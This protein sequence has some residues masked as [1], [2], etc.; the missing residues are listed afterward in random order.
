MLKTVSQYARKAM[1][2]VLRSDRF[3]PIRQQWAGLGAC[4]VYHRVVETPADAGAFAPYSG[5][6]VTAKQFRAQMQHVR[7]KYRCLPV[8]DLVARLRSGT[9]ERGS[10]AIT[11][12]DGYR[13]NLTVAL[14]ILEE[15]GIPATIFVSTGLIEEGTGLWW[16]D[17]QR[18]ISRYNS[19][20]FD[21]NGR[22]WEFELQTTELKTRATLVLN[23]I[24]KRLDPAQ[25]ATLFRSMDPHSEYPGNY[26]GEMLTWD[27]VEWLAR[28]P[29]ITIGAHTV[30]HPVLSRLREPQLSFELSESRRILAE[31]LRRTVSL[32]AY[33][34]GGPE[35]AGPREF[36]A[37]STTGFCA[38]FTTRFHHLQTTHRHTPH[39]LPR[40][41]I[42]DTDTPQ[43]FADKLTGLTAILL[44]PLPLHVS[45]TLR[46]V[47]E[48]LRKV[49]ETV[50]ASGS[51]RGVGW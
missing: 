15:L 34:Y 33:P 20:S 29:L 46:E 47:S 21:W 17:L 37:A 8:E 45:V 35:Q 36:A 51:F 12:D 39:G 10:V 25:Q 1:K 24:F 11:F 13:D 27:E 22:R 38:A 23:E 31:R 14:P 18:L 28:H 7:A 4:L 19:L 41:G 6:T 3:E 32:F 40:I 42:T 50:C 43:S 9:L 44:S 26:S 49:S 2:Q 48:T 16:Y 30:R 5:L